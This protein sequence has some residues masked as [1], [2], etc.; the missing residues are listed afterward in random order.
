[1][2]GAMVALASL[3]VACGPPC[4]GGNCEV[5]PLEA[6]AYVALMPVDR[7]E[8]GTLTVDDQTVVLTYADADGNV[9]EVTWDLGPTA[10][11]TE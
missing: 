4:G 1:M 3:L 8:D 9:W 5:L 11:T 7:G 2:R 6:G 10:I